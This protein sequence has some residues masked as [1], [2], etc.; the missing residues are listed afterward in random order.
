ML[1]EGATMA[2]PAFWCAEYLPDSPSTSKD[3]SDD[4]SNVAPRSTDSRKSSSRKRPFSALVENLKPETF[5]DGPEVKRRFMETALNESNTPF[6]VVDF[7]RAIQADNRVLNG[8]LA[9]ERTMFIDASS[10][11]KLQGDHILKQRRNIVRL[12]ADICEKEEADK[13][14]LPLAVQTMDRVLS[15][16]KIPSDRDL[17]Y[18]GMASLLLASK[19]KAC[20]PLS[21]QQLKYHTVFDANYVKKWEKLIVP[22]LEWNLSTPTAL[23][24]FD[25]L[26]ARAPDLNPLRE[27]FFQCLECVQEVY[28][29][30]AL[31]PSHQMAVVL[32]FLADIHNISLVQERIYEDFRLDE[33][34]I[35]KEVK[36][37]GQN[38]HIALTPPSSSS[39]SPGGMNTP[40]LKCY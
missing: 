31:P 35:N 27:D 39:S 9:M 1:T 22:R 14:V 32:F 19:M 36:V 12:L 17:A 13:S 34:V 30:A 40:G 5:K 24:F 6:V 26:L 33:C 16:Q 20:K 38:I 8:L 3:L 28:Q 15:I 21:T 11:K 25:H 18:V 10:M 2:S 23:E 29:L 37:I 4:G 7:D